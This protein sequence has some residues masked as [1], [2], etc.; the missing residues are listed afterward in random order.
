MSRNPE[1]SVLLI[2]DPQ[3]DFISGTLPV[4]GAAQAMDALA[5]YIR[6][7]SKDDYSKII[8]TSD[9]HSHKHCSFEPNG[10]PWPVHCLQHSAGAAIYEPL[11]EALCACELEFEVLYK[12]TLDDRE[13]YS[14]MQNAFSGDYLSSLIESGEIQSIDLCGLAGDV[15]V[16]NT[17][18]DLQGLLPGGL[19]ILEEYS[20]SLDGGKALSEFVAGL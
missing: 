6:T 13:E 5:E 17:A 7:L 16:L 10:G 15:C 20:P 12:G 11:L 3:I 2:V 19:R 8:V 9:F 4:P 1:T 18:K 14:I